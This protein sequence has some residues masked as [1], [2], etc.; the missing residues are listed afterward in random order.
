[1]MNLIRCS[2]VTEDPLY[3]SYHDK[4]WGVP[5][6]DDNLLFEFLTLEGAQ[7]GLSW[8]TILKKRHHYR[9]L[10]DH[11]DPVKVAAYTPEKIDVLILDKRII[12]NRRKISSTVQNAG[13]F[14]EIQSKF[15]TFDHYIW[16]FTDGRPLV[17]TWKSTHEIPAESPISKRMSKDL[18]TNGFKFVGPVICYAFMQAIGMVNDHT[19]DC[20]RYAE[21]NRSE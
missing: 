18:I 15:D 3:L 8:L 14:L 11:F 4:E 1:M 13:A 5:V 6:H 16:Q 7:A 9:M 2:W 17:N 20:F 10:F 21:I 12:R 19:V